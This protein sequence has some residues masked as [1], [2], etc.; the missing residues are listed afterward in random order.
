[1]KPIPE[2]DSVLSYPIPADHNRIMSRMTID[3]IPLIVCLDGIAVAYPLDGDTP[4]WSH[5]QDVPPSH[6]LERIERLAEII[7]THYPTS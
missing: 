1:M 5:Y 3:I 4:S 7:A 2:Y 6:A